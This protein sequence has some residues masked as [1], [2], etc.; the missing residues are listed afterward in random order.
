MLFQN[1][2]LFNVEE[3]VPTP[4]GLRIS[5]LPAHVREK[6]NN[7]VQTAS[8]FAADGV[9][10]RFVLQGPTATIRF[11][12]PNG[13]ANDLIPVI[14][15]FG[16]IQGGWLPWL[17]MKTLHPGLNELVIERPQY[18]DRFPEHAATYNHP[19][20]PCVVRVRLCSSCQYLLGI[21]GDIRP[22]KAEELPKLHGICYGSSITHGSLGILPN[23]MYVALCADA[24]RAD[25]RNLGFAGSCFLENA[26]GD[27]FAEQENLDFLCIELGT[28]L[29][30]WFPEDQFVERVTYILDRFRE[31]HPTT[32]II[33]IDILT[34]KPRDERCRTVVRELAAARNDPNLL[35]LCGRDLLENEDSVSADF[36]HPTME[37]Q[38]K[39]AQNL[40][41]A[42]QKMLNR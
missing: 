27:Y 39:I 10:I 17:T 2:E 16:N 11:N 1:A 42:I 12:L 38:R 21:E 24:L 23:Q 14:L 30:G 36:I 41:P 19:F 37:G 15:Y 18:E 33:L 28:N 8:A 6:M 7:I 34:V 31:T 29:F 22:P 35:A 5:R 13:K 9:E 26:M 25:I 40:A 20:A 3:L 4:H 32:P